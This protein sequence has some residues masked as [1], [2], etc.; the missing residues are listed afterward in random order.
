MTLLLARRSV[1]WGE[2]AAVLT[3]ESFARAA[4][5]LVPEPGAT[6]EAAA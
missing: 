2:T 1:G 3:P 4:A 5:M 6:R